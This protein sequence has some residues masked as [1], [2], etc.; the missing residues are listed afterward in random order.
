MRVATYNV[1]SG[2]F[3]DYTSSDLVPERLG[4]L[5]QAVKKIDADLIGLVDTFRWKE[6]YSE[7]DL[8]SWFGY[9]YVQHIDMNDTRVDKRIG[10][11]IL[12]R[13]PIAEWHVVRAYNRNAL[14]AMLMIDSV[15]TNVFLA[16]LDDL[17]EDTRLK[18]AA[19]IM[20]AAGSAA[21]VVM[22]DLNALTPVNVDGVRL[23]VAKY[24]G[25][26]PGD[27]NVS[28]LQPVVNE[29]L[30]AQVLPLFEKSGF[31]VYSNVSAPTALTSLHPLQMS[32]V[33]PIDYIIPRGLQ[34]KS[35]QVLKDPL[36][37]LASD[38]YPLVAQIL[39]N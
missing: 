21:A 3:G 19:A 26:S 1:M 4:L 5:Q 7:T 35:T 28:I 14:Q 34:V 17:S 16:Y 30:R 36:F 27:Q 20:E 11:A 25:G 31:N 2:G 32:P 12:S 6:L 38:H 29:F 13:E 24:L 18:E 8:S 37:E 23:E 39:A 15:Q 10:L 33:F 22:G 9:P